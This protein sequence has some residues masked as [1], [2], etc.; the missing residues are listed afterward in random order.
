MAV[1]LPPQARLKIFARFSVPVALWPSTVTV[2]VAASTAD[3]PVAGDWVELYNASDAA[4]DLTGYGL[5]DHRDEKGQKYFPGRLEERLRES[6]HLSAR[7]IFQ[8]IK[9]DLIAFNSQPDDDITFVII[10]KI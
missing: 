2:A 8:R 7:N 10:K 4:V 3:D 9:D 5:S 1:P 6:K